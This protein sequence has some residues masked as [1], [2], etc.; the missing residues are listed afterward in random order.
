MGNGYLSARAAAARLRV[1]PATLYAYVSRG[2]VRSEPGSGRRRRYLAADI[3]ALRRRQAA[4]REPAAALDWG[5]PVLDSAITSITPE[6]GRA[7]V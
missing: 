5:A 4:G 7:H 2:L 3:E 1:T 6:I